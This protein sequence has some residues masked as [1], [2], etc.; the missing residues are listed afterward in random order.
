MGIMQEVELKSKLARLLS[1]LNE[2]SEPHWHSYFLRASGLLTSG[3]VEAAKK[4]ILGAYG[5]MGSFNDALHFTGAPPEL[6]EEGFRLRKEIYQLC[7]RKSIVD[8]VV[9]L[10]RQ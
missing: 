1:L 5:G 4:T 7:K 9:H 8:A 6:A 2:Y 10:V 3:Q